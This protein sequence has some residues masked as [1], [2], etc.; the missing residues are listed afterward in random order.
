MSFS[1]LLCAACSGLQSEAELKNATKRVP[2]I[3]EVVDPQ[4]DSYLR[5]MVEEERFSGAAL[6]LQAGTII[7]AR[8]YGIATDDRDNA[9]DTVFHVASVTKQ[10]TAAAIL[11]LVERGMV[12]LDT[13][14]NEYLPEQS[15][16]FTTF[17]LT[18]A[19]CQTTH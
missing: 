4:Y 13:S 15:S 6:V 2:S 11:Q 8:G 16:T 10:F 19:E 9:V 18:Q 14:V 5:Q 3:S 1:L 7:H 12:N 17:S